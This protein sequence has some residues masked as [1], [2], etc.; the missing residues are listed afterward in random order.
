MLPE[1][2]LRLESGTAYDLLRDFSTITVAGTTLII[3]R[4]YGGHG[5]EAEAKFQK[6][7]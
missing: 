7:T 5:H 6:K 1:K 3:D 2:S 4:W